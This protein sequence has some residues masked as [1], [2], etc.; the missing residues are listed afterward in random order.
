MNGVRSISHYR[1]VQYARRNMSLPPACAARA[2][3]AAGCMELGVRSASGRAGR[4]ML[5]FFM[6]FDSSPCKRKV[7]L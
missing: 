2:L 7:S 1:G 4:M 3:G 5:Q 6:L